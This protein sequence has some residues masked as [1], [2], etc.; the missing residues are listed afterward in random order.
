MIV[1]SHE[2]LQEYNNYR[3]TDSLGYMPT[4]SIRPLIL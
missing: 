2:M 3:L 1:E 4:Q